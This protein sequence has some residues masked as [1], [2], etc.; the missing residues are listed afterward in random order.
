MGQ[1]RLQPHPKMPARSQQPASHM[2]CTSQSLDTLPAFQ[3]LQEEDTQT[4]TKT[5]QWEVNLFKLN[6]KINANRF[7]PAEFAQQRFR[8]DENASDPVLKSP[9]TSLHQL[10]AFNHKL[11]SRQHSQAQHPSSSSLPTALA[12]GATL[13]SWTGTEIQLLPGLYQPGQRDGGGEG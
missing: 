7:E 1:A 6:K 13:C 12:P 5:H 9:K 10:T 4:S 11:L 8:S 2:T 3:W